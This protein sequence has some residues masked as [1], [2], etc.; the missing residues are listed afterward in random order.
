MRWALWVPSSTLFNLSLLPC[1]IQILSSVLLL[2]LLIYNLLINQKIKQKRLKIIEKKRLVGY[3]I[4]R[5]G[6]VFPF[7]AHHTHTQL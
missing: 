3:S 5:S 6:M 1:I 7:Y 2:Q 4:Y